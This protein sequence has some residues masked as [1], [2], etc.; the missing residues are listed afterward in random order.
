MTEEIVTRKN[1][2][3]VISKAANEHGWHDLQTN[4]AWSCNPYGDDYAVVPDDL[5]PE[6][7]ETCG[8]CT[9]RLNKE[10]TEITRF[11]PIEI[12]EFPEPEREP[13]ENELQWQAITDLEI[14][15]MEY[16]QALT[17]LEIEVLGDE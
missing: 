6:I 2:F 10:G 13:T 11:K 12:P 14:E 8:Y 3:C 9:I 15:Q 7:M 4:S 1:P 5:V 16:W 17:D